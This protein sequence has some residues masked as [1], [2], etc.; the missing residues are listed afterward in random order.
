MS[1][2][3]ARTLRLLSLLQARRYWSGADLAGRLGVSVRTLRRD[4]DRLRE[5]GY[6]VDASR[7]VDGGYTL[8]PGAA[9][10]PLVLDDDEAVA[11]A[12]GLQAAAAGPVAGMAETSVRVLAKLVQVMPVRLRRRVEALRAVTVPAGVAPPPGSADA[13]DPAVLTAVALA[14]RDTER[15]A[16]GYAPPDR[17]RT[18]RTVEPHRLVALGRRWYLVGWDLDRG[19]WRVFRLD[20]LD[21]PRGT[22]AVFGPRRFPARDAAVYVRERIGGAW[23]RL[24]AEAVVSAPAR[25]VRARIGPWATVTDD[26]P[27]RCR[28]RI[29]ADD[30]DWAVAA[31]GLTGAAFTVVSP[32]EV[33]DHLRVVADRYAA[34]AR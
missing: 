6:P 17:E 18:E 33:R 9:L 30:V 21:A 20:R 29:E 8:A 26:G 27:G 22:G 31:L 5:L 1:D 14:C 23:G 32:P 11:L 10:P 19:D 15:I 3:G 4:V 13:V 24:V 25:Q 28:V 16:F 34:A 12:V 7:G 2:P